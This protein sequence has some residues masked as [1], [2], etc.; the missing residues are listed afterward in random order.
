M[1]MVLQSTRWRSM[2]LQQDT[3]YLMCCITVLF[4]MMSASTMPFRRLTHGRCADTLLPSHVNACPRN[5][6][7]LFGRLEPGTCPDAGYVV[8]AGQHRVLAGP[9][10]YITF[11]VYDQGVA[12]LAPVHHTADSYLTTPIAFCLAPTLRALVAESRSHHVFS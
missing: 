12:S 11:D 2:K 7:V 10:G 5:V 8:P 9:C 6:V 4:P 3:L 1:N